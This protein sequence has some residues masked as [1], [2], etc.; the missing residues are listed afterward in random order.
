MSERPTVSVIIPAFNE[1]GNIATLFA[2]IDEGL[3]AAGLPGETV[4]VDD[5]STDGTWERVE[6]ERAQRPNVRA[7]RHR[8]N[9]GL[10][11]ALNTGFRNIRGD[12]IVFL[13]ADL[14]SDPAEDI[15]KL[16]AELRAGNDVAVGWR[17][18]RREGKLFVSLVYN[19]LCRHLFGIDAHDLNWIKAFRREVIDTIH[20]RS[21]WHRYVVV[22]AAGRGFRV[23]E[24]RTSY[25]PRHSGQSK[26]GRKR[27]LRGL[28]DLLV[29][30]FEIAFT[31]KPM[32]LFGSW[33]I[34]GL[35][36]GVLL[37]IALV[38]QKAVTGVGSR[39]LLFLAMLLVMVG[40]QL[41]GLGFVSE[42]IASLREALR[43]ARGGEGPTPEDRGETAEAGRGKEDAGEAA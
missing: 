3:S 37:G 30:K 31:D 35:A 16:L 39:P 17:V 10:S 27:I 41:L 29:V 34:S 40:V 22:L 21:D 19:F 11:E 6:A 4:F 15:P 33:G 42:Q 32:L 13:P 20:L 12:Y 7:F 2:K 1:E 9:F 14:Q 23:K 24:I 28:L 25:Y 18:G 43:G 36:L 38:V 5:G 26:F 8:R